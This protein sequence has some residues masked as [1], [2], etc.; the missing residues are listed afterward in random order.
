MAMRDA[1][2]EEDLTRGGAEANAVTVDGSEKFGLVIGG[3]AGGMSAAA[4]LGQR[5]SLSAR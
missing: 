5:F 3:V 2:L 1:L 4:Q